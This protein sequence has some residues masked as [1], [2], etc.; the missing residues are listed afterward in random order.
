MSTTTTESPAVEVEDTTPEPV[1]HVD[2]L[3]E[4]A[5]PEDGDDTRPG[6]EAAK[7]RRQLREVEGERDTLAGQLDALRRA[8][9][10]RIAAQGVEVVA[11]VTAGPMAGRP[12]RSYTVPGIKPAALWASGAQLG[13][14]LADDGTVDPE[15]VAEAVKTARDVLGLATPSTPTAFAAGNVGSPLPDPGD[16]PAFDKA[17]APNRTI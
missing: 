10:E 12:M 2:S 3:G 8:E 14:L 5:E 6:R 15:K 11:R 13:D 16:R 1:Q 9:A 7:Y 4:A 17:F